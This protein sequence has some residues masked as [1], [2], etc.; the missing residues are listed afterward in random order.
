LEDLDW[1]EEKARAHHTVIDAV[2][3]Q[4]PLVPMRLATVYHSEAGVTELLTGRSRD[5]RALLDRIRGRREW[6]VKAYTAHV[7]PAGGG[8]AGGGGAGGGG[9]GGRRRRAGL[10]GPA[11]AGSGPPG[12]RPAGGRCPAHPRFTPRPRG[13]PCPSGCPRR[14]P[15]SCTGTRSPCC[16]TAPTC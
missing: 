14:R 15:R 8:R 16:S 5:F 11:A 4:Q 9:P 12:R 2:A 3:Q 6:G 13:S 7:A 1:L 10:P